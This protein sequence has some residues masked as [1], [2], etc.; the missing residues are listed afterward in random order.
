MQV[1]TLA[2]IVQQPV[3]ITEFKLAGDLIHGLLMR[4]NDWPLVRIEHLTILT[5]QADFGIGKH[6]RAAPV[7]AR[8]VRQKKSTTINTQPRPFLGHSFINNITTATEAMPKVEG[9][10]AG[11]NAV[12]VPVPV[13]NEMLLSASSNS[14]V[15]AVTNASV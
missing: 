15:P 6:V 12:S 8:S 5:T 11:M 3:A 10:G 4:L 14:D 13:V 2:R 9:S 7:F 1:A